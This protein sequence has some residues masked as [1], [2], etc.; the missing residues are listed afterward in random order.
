MW[1]W[2]VGGCRIPTSLAQEISYHLSIVELR[3]PGGHQ[4]DMVAPRWWCGAHLMATVAAFLGV[5]TRCALVSLLR[6]AK[7]FGATALSA[8]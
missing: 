8:P 2:W 6:D 4:V 1:S 7:P 3:P 5:V